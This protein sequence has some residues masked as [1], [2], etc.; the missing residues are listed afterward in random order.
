MPNEI[1]GALAPLPPWLLM[2]ALLGAINAAACFLIVGRRVAHLAWYAILGMLAAGLGQLLA[3][4]IEAPAPIRI[5]ELNVLAA[6][7]AVWAVLLLTRL[8]GL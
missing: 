6:S 5:G 2:A 7:L 1:A 4:T 3:T 8:A